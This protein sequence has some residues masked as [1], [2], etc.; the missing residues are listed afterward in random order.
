VKERRGAAIGLERHVVQLSAPDPAWRAAFESER[1]DLARLLAGLV[2]DVQH[3]GSTAIPDLCAKPVIDVLVGLTSFTDVDEAVRLLVQSGYHDRGRAEGG[4]H[5]VA[6]GPPERRTHYV[7]VVGHG[8]DEWEDKVLFRDYLLRHPER[9]TAYEVLK[10]GLAQRHVVDRP[11]YTTA[12]HA[13]VI[14]TV[15]LARA[16]NPDGC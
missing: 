7:H 11:S 5:H 10:R 16:E 12:K 2:V 4:R 8:S 6:K 15:A 3:V 9:V 13:F 1:D 14:E